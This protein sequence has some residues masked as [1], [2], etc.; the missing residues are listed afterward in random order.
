[1]K[2]R[3]KMCNP[4]N[5]TLSLAL[6]S[7]AKFIPSLNHTSVSCQPTFCVQFYGKGDYQLWHIKLGDVKLN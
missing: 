6:E 1:M 4:S 5:E 2:E 3:P 7:H